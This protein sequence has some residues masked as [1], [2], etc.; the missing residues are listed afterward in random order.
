MSNKV[1]IQNGPKNR[2]PRDTWKDVQ[3]HLLLEK[4]KSKLWGITSH[5]LE[6]PST[7][8]LQT[9]NAKEGVGKGNP[10]IL[11]VGM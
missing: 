3:H 9:I 10:P 11:L 5:W 6:C 2:W 8:N 7:R 1:D 4:C